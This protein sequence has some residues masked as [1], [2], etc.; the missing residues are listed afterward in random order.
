MAKIEFSPSF[1]SGLPTRILRYN[2]SATGQIPAVS[3]LLPAGTDS[4]TSQSSGF[5]Y[6]M[7]GVVPTNFSSL[8]AFNV[9]ST[10]VLCMWRVRDGSFAPSQQNVNPAVVSSTYQTAT[11]TG[12]ATWF[13]WN[14]RPAYDQDNQN[15]LIH[16][17]IGTVGLTGSG[18]DLEMG[19]TNL[20]AGEQYRVLNIR[21]QFPSSWVF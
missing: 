1:M 6:L 20:V 14:V 2:E 7:K 3:G 15:L 21:L 11:Q 17:I 16:Q 5:L 19:T 9:R 13:W 18:A 8:T 10:D 4:Y 12:T